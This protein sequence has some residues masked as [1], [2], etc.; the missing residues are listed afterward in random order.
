[1]ALK[2][3]DSYEYR[4]LDSSSNSVHFSVK[5]ISL[6]THCS[7]L[8]NEVSPYYRIFWI[9]D[10]SGLYDIDFTTFSIDGS[11]IFCVSPNQIF[12]VRNEKVKTAYVLSFDK[13]F[14]CVETHGKEIS[15]N[16]LL[17]NNVHRATGVSVEQKDTALFSVLIDNMI[18]EIS[19]PGNAHRE[20]LETYL[21][22]FMIQTLRLID[23]EEQKISVETHQRNQ[24]VLDFIALVDKHFRTKHAVS[25]YASEL[26]ISPKS[27]TKKLKSLGYATPTK[28][29]RERIM[30]EAKRELKYGTDNVKEIAYEL[31]FEDPAYFSRLFS[32]EEGLSPLEY[33]KG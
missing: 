20:M 16:G 30:I 24:I 18:N 8:Q 21:R 22:M 3:V 1:M 15:C 2:T 32:K 10:G 6:E 28:V 14:Y 25:D 5:K 26:F 9:E 31:G 4:K 7:A 33:R 29:I 19:N 27:L 12:L 11:G 17:F 23:D 13:E